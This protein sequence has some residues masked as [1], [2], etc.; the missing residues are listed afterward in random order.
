[1]ACVAEFG[2]YCCDGGL[3]VA[4]HTG[5]ALITRTFLIFFLADTPF[6]LTPT[7]PPPTWAKHGPIQHVGPASYTVKPTDGHVYLS[8][9]GVCEHRIGCVVHQQTASG[10]E[11][12]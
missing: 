3:H 7:T 4:P 12:R 2:V 5:I 11:H 10:V 6:T 9:A 8:S 1:V